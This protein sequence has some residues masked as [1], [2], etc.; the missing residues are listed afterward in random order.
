MESRNPGVR[1]ISG[2]GV[3]FLVAFV[4][5]LA[6]ALL[7]PHA[8][9]VDTGPSQLAPASAVTGLA[10]GASTTGSP[11]V[12]AVPSAPVERQG[13]GLTAAASS[14]AAASLSRGVDA[15]LGFAAVCVLVLLLTFAL[16]A[17]R[18]AP[19]RA[20]VHRSPTQLPLRRV[21]RPRAS[22][23]HLFLLFSI[24]RT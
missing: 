20:T 4:S 16:L 6:L 3:L 13:S 24:S 19:H 11:E 7:G 18:A 17:M 2:R 14:P 10:G 1:P 22:A 8:H 21:P 12:S 15:S 9:G 5:F 23:Q